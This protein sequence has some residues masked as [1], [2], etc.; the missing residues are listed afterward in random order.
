MRRRLQ[1]LAL[2]SLL[3][4]SLA[5]P[6]WG[7]ALSRQAQQGLTLVQQGRYAQAIPLLQQALQQSPDELAI[8]IGLATSFRRL[9]RN[10]EATD[11]YDRILRQ[12]PNNMIGL[13]GMALVGGFVPERRPQALQALNTLLEKDPDSLDSVE[14]RYQRAL[15]LMYAGRHQESLQD[16]ELVLSRR[17]D[18]E[19]LKTAAQ[20]NS[21]VQNFPE[22][23]R[24]FEA[25]LQANPRILDTNARL[26]YARSLVGANQVAKGLEILERLRQ[27]NPNN[28][29]ILLVY[30]QALQSAG[31]HAEANQIL[32]Q[33]AADPRSVLIRA[34]ALANLRQFAEAGSLYQQA[35]A[36]DPNNLALKREAADVLS[37]S[38]SQR[39]L[40]LQLYQQL[41]ATQPSPE[42][43]IKVLQLQVQLN[44]ISGAALQSRVL[45]LL[46]RS[47]DRPQNQ[48]ELLDLLVN[49]PASPSLIPFYQDAL[50]A[51]LASPLLRLRLAE[52]YLLAQQPQAAKTILNALQLPT[53][54]APELLLYQADLERRSG[55]LTRAATLLQTLTRRDPQNQ[56]ALQALAAIQQEQ[57]Q[58]NLAVTTLEQL[59]RL[60]S[61]DPKIQRQLGEAYLGAR[62]FAQ[63]AQTLLPL[64]NRDPEVALPLARALANSN[65]QQ[66]AATYYLQALN[67]IPNPSPEL[68]QEVADVLSGIPGQEG[69]ALELYRRLARLRP[70]DRTIATRLLILENSQRPLSAQDLVRR[71]QGD[72][73]IAAASPPEREQLARL[74]TS[75]PADPA[76]L[77]FYQE[78]LNAG[79]RDPLIRL[80]QAQALAKAGQREAARAALNAL[81][82]EQPNTK[83]AYYALADLEQEAG[84]IA[85]AI[86]AYQAITRLDPQDIDALRAVA[87]LSQRLG[88]NATALA[89]ARALVAQNPG[90]PRAKITLGEILIANRQ[91]GEAIDIL[92]PLTASTPAALLPL[93]RAYA[94]SGQGSFAVPLYL[95][96]LQA[97]RPADPKVVLEAADV[98]KGVPGQEQVALQLLQQLSAADPQNPT[99]RLRLLALRAELGQIP[100]ETLRATLLQELG[101][102]PDPERLRPLA[103]VLAQIPGDPLLL[104]YYGPAVSLAPD[105]PRILLRWG[106]AAQAAG[107]VATARTVLNQYLVKEPNDVGALFTLANL[108]RQQGNLSATIPLYQRIMAVRPID[109]QAF[110]GALDT[111]AGVYLQLNQPAQAAQ[112]YLQALQQN[113]NNFN[114]RLDYTRTAYLG[115]LINEARAGE[116]LIY[117]FSAGNPRDPQQAQRARALLDALPTRP[118]LLGV[119]QNLAARAPTNPLLQIK[120]AQT[121]AIRDPQGAE[122]YLL[123]FFQ[124]QPADLDTALAIADLSI[125]NRNFAQAESIYRQILARDPGNLRTFVAMA[126]LEYER[127]NYTQ[128]EQMFQQLL[129]LQ[130]RDPQVYTALIDLAV[131]RGK[132]VEALNLIAQAE[133][134]VG[135][136][137][138]GSRPFQIK[139]DLLRQQGFALPWERF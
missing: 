73:S 70:E 129:Q 2:V 114:D 56:A 42:L 50:N 45:S 127:G 87:G 68:L 51:N 44:Q 40:A 123:N 111:L 27:E 24:L 48:Q 90:D 131:A 37:A 77:P 18:A 11:M 105:N 98:A 82:Q 32:T 60:N 137:V 121:L 109:Q 86:R 130:P 3:G 59:Q 96:A 120:Y 46:Q 57:Q 135:I 8:L 94:E 100:P 139:Q 5:S 22:A 125:R 124:R 39:P 35:L 14:L 106:E 112:L 67:R 23:V 115:K 81:I 83:D 92:R 104:P 84:D 118:E 88:D 89:A 76:L 72:V 75:L 47:Q 71:L 36:A 78:L 26:D 93:A 108:E 52:A 134:S 19:V 119:Y 102:S 138:L 65:Q 49:L 126:A 99:Y 54:A 79:L 13:Q 10:R 110:R 1:A 122:R 4:C 25:A 31:R 38:D 91:F 30:G 113:P 58:F 74:L 101:P 117:W 97:A 85:A 66:Q 133:S 80:R 12:D 103:P 17:R 128:A 21:Y 69:Q 43:E 136:G 95:Q 55:N 9:G 20:V 15:V 29:E 63:A 33:I 64:V 62:Q 16:L 6:V 34:R 53:T 28:S 7:Q 116:E 61:N 132:R 41:L 107:D